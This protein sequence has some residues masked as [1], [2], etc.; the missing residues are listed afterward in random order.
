MLDAAN[1]GAGVCACF[2]GENMKLPDRMFR[3]LRTCEADEDACFPPTEVFNEGWMLRLV[4][5][6]FQSLNLTLGSLR[7]ARDAKWFSEAL[8]ESP[9]KPSLRAD[10]LGEGFTNAD[11][12]IGNFEFRPA[13][14]AGLRLHQDASQF[15]VVE[16]KMFS[17]LSAGTK[18]APGYNQAARNV[19][20]IA[21]AVAKSG[22]SV[23]SFASLGF[24]V[25][26]PDKRHRKPG[27]TNLESSMDPE[28]IRVAVDQ[29]IRAYEAAERPE[30]RKLRQ[31]QAANFAPLVERLATQGSLA[32]LSWENCISQIATADASG[33]DELKAFY[34][35]CL[36]YAPAR[37]VAQ[38]EPLE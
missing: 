31:W 16:A 21:E 17:N 10:P 32:V 3:L 2:R 38:A 29:R 26:A 23:E 9:F 4:L 1:V 30:A 20:C 19:A 6:A 22:R 28:A 27:Y 34:D 14:R 7:F 24:F 12:V 13:T 11:A 8:L 36:A 35:R 5:D 33:G 25:I 18:N 37:E 15:V